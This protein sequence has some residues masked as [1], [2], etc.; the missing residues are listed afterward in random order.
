[1][2]S[3]DPAFY[4]TLYSEKAMP[5]LRLETATPTETDKIIRQQAREI[6]G[7]TQ[8]VQDLKRTML[9]LFQEMVNEL[10]SEDMRPAI[11]KPGIAKKL[12]ELL[13]KFEG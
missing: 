11:A 1:M 13:E 3:G 12:Q 7:L 6:E 8:R 10:G 5:F 4:R 9:A 2:D